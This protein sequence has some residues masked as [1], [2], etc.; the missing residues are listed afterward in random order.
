MFI[1][2]TNHLSQY[3]SQEQLAAAHQYGEIIDLPFPS[4]DPQASSS[5]VMDLAQ[6]YAGRIIALHPTA[7]LCQGEFIYCHALVERL[8]AVGITVLAATSER[9]VEESYHD[10]VNE[11]RVNFQFV[12]FR[13]YI[14]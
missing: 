11:K 8:L 5:T 12:Q 2:H 9:V 13:E 14:R 4:I 6:E 7:V 3:W 10:G 1:N